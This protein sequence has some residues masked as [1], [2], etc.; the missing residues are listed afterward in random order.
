VRL[1]GGPS[2]D[3]VAFLPE[4][5]DEACRS[6]RQPD[7]GL[8]ELRNGPF[9]FV[10]SKVMVWMALERAERLARRGVI[11]GDVEAWRTTREQ[12]AEEVLTRGFD[13]EL[14]AF[15]QSYERPVLDA[16]NLLLAMQE[17]LPFDDPRVQQNLDRTLADLA[18]GACVHRYEADDGI[19][20]GEGA[21]GLCSFW[22]VDALAMAG[23]VDEAE[24]IFEAMAA[25]ANHV[26][27]F[28]EMLD[29]VT[30]TFLG[31]FPQAFT[32][33]GL[34]NSSL[35]L[36]HARGRELPIPSLIGSHDHRREP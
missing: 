12:I 14:G 5:A 17:F 26:G 2:D 4:V 21:F 9:S 31:N 24:E 20:G 23:R 1:G 35:Y 34:I 13:P 11:D 8:W 33:L 25:S 10:Y 18:D 30:G 27:L 22:L 3:V 36:A 15:K 19:A 28:S 32:H 29:P 16:S 6:W 7:Y